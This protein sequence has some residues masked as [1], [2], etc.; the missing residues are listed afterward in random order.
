[1]VG[2]IFVRALC[3]PGSLRRRALPERP[4]FQRRR[5]HHGPRQAL[6]SAPEFSRSPFSYSHT[7]C[8]HP[9]ERH[10]PPTCGCSPARRPGDFN[11]FADD[12][13]GTESLR[14][15]AIFRHRINM[16][17]TYLSS[18]CWNI[19]HSSMKFVYLKMDALRQLGRGMSIPEHHR[20]PQDLSH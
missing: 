10:C 16:K 20:H 17:G 18:G 3:S 14:R 6:V 13:P 1:M 7:Q 15:V 5:R 11:A 8:L 9:A 2:Q 4:F 12:E 19:T